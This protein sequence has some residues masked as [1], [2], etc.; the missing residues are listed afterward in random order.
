MS[1]THDATELAAVPGVTEW[2]PAMVLNIQHP[3][4]LIILNQPIEDWTVLKLVWQNAVY[5]IAADGGANRL[6]EGLK[7][8][9]FKD[10][11]SLD[12]ICG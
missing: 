1:Q 3:H 2:N 11:P 8:V 6:E 7:S 10:S 12:A 5:R 4:A 9:Y